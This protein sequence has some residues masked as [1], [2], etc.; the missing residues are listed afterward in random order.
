MALAALELQ[1]VIPEL[2]RLAGTKFELRVG[3]HVGPVVGGVVGI[4]NPRYHVFGDAVALA[5]AMESSGQVG[6]VHCSSAVYEKLKGDPRFQFVAHPKEE[7]SG[8][9]ELETFFITETP[10]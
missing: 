7:V 6:R 9:G 1:N 8:F 5:N 2:Q 10:K 3:M 4:N